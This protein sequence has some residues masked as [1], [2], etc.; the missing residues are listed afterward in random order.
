[1]ARWVS[2]GLR[3]AGSRNRTRSGN[4]RPI[5]PAYAVKVDRAAHVEYGDRALA[6][7]NEIL[8]PVVGPAV[9]GIA[10]AGTDDHDEMGVY[11]APPEFIVGL[12]QAF[13][14]LPARGSGSIRSFAHGAQPQVDSRHGDRSRDWVWSGW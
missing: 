12:A 4:F 13:I 6:P 8:R 1:M 2:T 5:R 14:A 3:A 10:I 7:T 9:H 11:V